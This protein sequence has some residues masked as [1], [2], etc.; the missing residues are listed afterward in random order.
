MT[1]ERVSNS[2]IVSSTFNDRIGDLNLIDSAWHP[3]N[4]AAASPIMN[5]LHVGI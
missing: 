1:H 2:P 5:V 4:A 3:E